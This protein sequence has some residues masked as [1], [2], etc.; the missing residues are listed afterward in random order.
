M[1]FIMNRP[2]TLLLHA[3]CLPAAVSLCSLSASISAALYWYSHSP[4]SSRSAVMWVVME[5]C[6][7]GLCIPEV[8]MHTGWWGFKCVC[9]CGCRVVRENSTGI[10][11]IFPAPCNLMEQIDGKV[12]GRRKGHRQTFRSVSWYARMY[13]I[14]I[15]T[16]DS[17]IR[18]NMFNYMLMQICNPRAT[19]RQLK[20]TWWKWCAWVLTK[21]HNRSERWFTWL[22]TGCGC[23][24]WESTFK[25]FRN[26]RFF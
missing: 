18:N 25:C 2:L 23:R 13:Q 7:G 24:C 1:S 10:N 17:F 15:H 4:A 6:M 19:W 16:L 22:W 20:W 3:V 21:H 14:S 8:L 26:C 12:R 9:V 11:S 5:E